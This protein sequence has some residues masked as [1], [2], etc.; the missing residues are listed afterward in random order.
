MLLEAD[1]AGSRA[2]TDAQRGV[3]QDRRDVIELECP[4]KAVGVGSRSSSHDEA[5]PIQ[6]RA[7]SEGVAAPSPVF[8]LAVS[9]EIVGGA[10]APRYAPGLDPVDSAQGH[11]EP[12]CGEL[13]ETA[14]DSEKT[15]ARERASYTNHRT[16]SSKISQL[17]LRLL[18]AASASEPISPQ[19]QNLGSC[20]GLIN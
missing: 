5:T 2:A 15:I 4:K 17:R 11:P 19:L 9:I 18:V 13:V 20:R 8:T 14:R 10:L 7:F 3:L 12:A 16:A 1:R 6:A